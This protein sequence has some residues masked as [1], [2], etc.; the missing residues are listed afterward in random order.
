[1]LK[2]LPFVAEDDFS[3]SISLQARIVSPTVGND[4]KSFHV[5]NCPLETNA[6]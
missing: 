1:M 4:V 3:L 6:S 5:S 2:I